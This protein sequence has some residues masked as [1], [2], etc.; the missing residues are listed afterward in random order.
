M[1]AAAGLALTSALIAGAMIAGKEAVNLSGTW[2]GD[3]LPA[4]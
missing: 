2:V 3:E 1:L 4:G